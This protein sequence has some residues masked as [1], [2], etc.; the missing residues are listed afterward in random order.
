MT[1]YYF[2]LFRILNEYNWKFISKIILWYITKIGMERGNS[3]LKNE[4]S[5]DEMHK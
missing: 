1:L 2:L 5:P 3:S 4:D